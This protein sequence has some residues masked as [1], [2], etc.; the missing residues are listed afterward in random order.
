MNEFFPKFFPLEAPIQPKINSLLISFYNFPL[1]IYNKYDL[2]SFKTVDSFLYSKG[3]L[4]TFENDLNIF[5]ESSYL[6]KYILK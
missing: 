3:E 1:V 5:N 4:K 6:F 2:I